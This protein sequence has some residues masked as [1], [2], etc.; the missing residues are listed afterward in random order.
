MMDGRGFTLTRVFEVQRCIETRSFASP[1]D[2]VCDIVPSLAPASHARATMDH[3]Q[4]TVRR[5]FPMREATQRPRVGT[6]FVI[7]ILL[8]PAGRRRA[9][10]QRQRH[11][12]Y[13]G[14]ERSPEGLLASRTIAQKIPSTFGVNALSEPSADAMVLGLRKRGGT[15]PPHVRTSQSGWIVHGTDRVIACKLSDHCDHGTSEENRRSYSIACSMRKTWPPRVDGSTITALA[16]DS[17]LHWVGI[18]RPARLPFW[19][20]SLSPPENDVH[21]RLKNL[22]LQ[23]DS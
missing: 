19:S 18:S 5:L 14:D 22:S 3:D 10:Q 8:P 16:S 6:G 15:C 4:P 13:D 9:V 1:K 2:R 7:V 20:A 11:E 17:L 21:D 12:D 23:E